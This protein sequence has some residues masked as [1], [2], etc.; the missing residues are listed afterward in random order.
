MENNVVCPKCGLINEYRTE[1]AGVHTKAICNGCNSYI[2]FL[3]Q[4]NPP[5]IHFGKYSG[6]EI[7][8]MVSEE[9]IKYLHWMLGENKFKGKLKTD[10][11]S[12]LMSL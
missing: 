4:G 8:T 2:K 11:E 9:E 3:P 10:I 7:S 5:T 1:P 12:H 6:I